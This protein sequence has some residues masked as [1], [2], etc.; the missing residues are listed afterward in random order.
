MRELSGDAWINGWMDGRGEERRWNGR[1]IELWPPE[2]TDG[3]I[4]EWMM[5]AMVVVVESVSY[6]PYKP[7]HPVVE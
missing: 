6:R 3:L 7:T 4:N 1:R 5:V 2:W